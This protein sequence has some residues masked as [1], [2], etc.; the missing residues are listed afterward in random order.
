MA[1]LESLIKYK[2]HDV[3][4]KRKVLAKL[5]EQAESLMSAKKEIEEQLEKETVLALE[6]GTAEALSDLGTYS[7][8]IKKRISSFNDSIKEM[9]KRISIAQEDMRE[10]FAEMKKVEI[11]QRN[12][13][14]RERRKL[15]KKESDELDEIGL[16]SYRRHLEEE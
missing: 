8:A 5:Y 1:D 11:T 10:A 12:R 16:D 6:L 3:D 4:E 13:K 2:R 9:D 15:N 7:I 14:D